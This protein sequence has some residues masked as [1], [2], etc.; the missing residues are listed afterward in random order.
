VAEAFA[1][2]GTPGPTQFHFQAPG[3]TC[4][5]VKAAGTDVVSIADSHTLDHVL[6]GRAWR[7]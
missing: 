1:A 4:D 5:A 6:F 7:G 3:S 2:R